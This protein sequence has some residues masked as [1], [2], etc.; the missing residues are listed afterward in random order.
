MV[1]YILGIY[2]GH[3]ISKLTEFFYKFYL[4]YFDNSQSISS[5][6][7]YKQAYSKIYLDEINDTF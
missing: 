4:E 6:L 1:F 5:I 3:P 2:F 7:E